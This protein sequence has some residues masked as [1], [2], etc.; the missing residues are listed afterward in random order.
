[1]NAQEREYFNEL[2][3]DRAQI[4]DAFDKPAARGIRKS[5]SEKYSD[6]AHFVYELL[7]NA[8]DANATSARFILFKDRLVFAHNGTR[9]FSVSNPATEDADSEN[10]TLG[11]L[12]AITSYANSNKREASIGKFGVGFKAVFQ[13]TATPHIYDP[14]VFFKLD[15]EIVPSE[16]KSDYQD[17]L[18]LCYFGFVR[19]TLFFALL[20]IEVY[21]EEHPVLQKLISLGHSLED[22]PDA[23]SP[24]KNLLRGQQLSHTI[25]ALFAYSYI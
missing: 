7:Q 4:A 2:S 22:M 18:A 8:D 13:Y 24:N 23:T 10:R 25:S 14:D 9:R 17:R 16:I 11:D 12:N 19:M 5:V 20:N 6:H 1:M 21:R 15:R 3:K